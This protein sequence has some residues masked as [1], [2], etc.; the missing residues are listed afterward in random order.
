[1][2]MP[3]LNADLQFGT[4]PF[5]VLSAEVWLLVALAL[6]FDFLNGFHDAANSV[7]TIVATRVLRPL[8]AVAWAAFFNFVAFLVFGLN[9]AA[10]IGKGLLDQ[11]VL[12]NRLI[13]AALV[14]ACAW[15]IITWYLALPTSSSHALVGGMVGAA[16]VK[17][18]GAAVQWG[19]IGTIV[20]FIFLA[21]LLGM[22]LGSVLAT[23]VL[24]LFRR[25]R[26]RRVD[27]IFRIGQ[28]VSAA[29]YSLGHGGNDAQKTMGLI[30]ALL[31]AAAPRTG[32]SAPAQVPIEVVL[33]C[34]AAMA[35]GTLSG[36]WRI[37][38]TM[39][40][41][42]IHLRPVDGFCAEAAAA[43]TLT[44]TVFLGVPVSTTH[45]IAGSI[46]GVGLLKRWRSVRWRVA[47]SVV[48]AWVLTIP[49]AAVIAAGSWW[50]L[51][52]TGLLSGV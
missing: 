5:G 28:L 47:Q 41:R 10:T 37:I 42:L 34:H 31:I 39:G 51:R 43:G 17:A 35:L 2:S 4:V 23:A 44:M 12:D 14:G 15:D 27:R 30:F 25:V 32:Y 16:L 40:Q 29:G 7:A 11:Q 20:L 49:G 26:L 3:F 18:G 36:G 13:A 45:T 38:H 21:P 46:V 48:W 9:V 19:E 50:L 6:V 8:V 52:L 1:M 24:W 22:V 33:A